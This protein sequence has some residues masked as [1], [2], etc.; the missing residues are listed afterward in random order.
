[1]IAGRASSWVS[2]LPGPGDNADFLSL[3]NPA[4][5]DDARVQRQG[6]V[7]ALNDFLQD[8]R[9]LHERVWIER[10]HHASRAQVDQR[11]NHVADAQVSSG[12]VSFL[13]AGH[14][15]DD[16]VRPEPPAIVAERRNGTVSRD[17]LL[18]SSRQTAVSVL[19]VDRAVAVDSVD[20]D[21]DVFKAF[22]AHRLDRIAPDFSDEHERSV[23]RMGVAG[24]DRW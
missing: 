9:V 11:D 13:E 22:P 8:V 20:A 23:A 5:A 7:E 1:M 3:M 10:R 4:A 2:V 15:S 16:D 18:S 14:A 21:V 6:P 24:H 12:P 19:D 17:E